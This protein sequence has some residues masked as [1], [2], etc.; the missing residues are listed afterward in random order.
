MFEIIQKIIA[1]QMN[2]SDFNLIS[3]DTDLSDDL[4]ADSI[5][6]AEIIIAI[7]NEFDLE[8]PDDI[9]VNIK[10]VSEIIKYLESI[11]E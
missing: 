9:V 11:T 7:E 2:I 1:E 8:I 3:E 4:N 5:D 6:A 10:K